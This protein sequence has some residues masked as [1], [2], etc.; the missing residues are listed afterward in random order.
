MPLTPAEDD[1]VV[2]GARAAF[3]HVHGL[4]AAVMG[5][6]KSSLRLSAAQPYPVRRYRIGRAGAMASAAAMIACASMP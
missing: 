3:T 1:Q 6:G 2:T 4:V 5:P